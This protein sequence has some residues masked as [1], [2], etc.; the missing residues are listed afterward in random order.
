MEVSG[1]LRAAEGGR[2]SSNTSPKPSGFVNIAGRPEFCFH[3][4]LLDEV[5]VMAVST[6]DLT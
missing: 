3:R 2:T 4:L 1:R 6:E 5:G